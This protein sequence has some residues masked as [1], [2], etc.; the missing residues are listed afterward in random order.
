MR[1]ALILIP[2]VVACSRSQQ[3][4]GNA[5]A[6]GPMALTEADIAGTWTGTSM[7]E[8]SDSVVVRWTQVCANGACTGT[9]EGTAD[10]I[11]STYTLSGDSAVGKSAPYA[12]A[13][14]GG[15]KAVDSWTVRL[16]DGK[17]VGTG[18]LTLADKPDSVLMRYHFE[19]SRM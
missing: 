11:R 3:T 19:G 4:Q 18:A 12:S 9:I 7:P 15:A 2:L 16:R 13:D 10:T 14:A 8:G 5:A 17:A 6:A 1:R